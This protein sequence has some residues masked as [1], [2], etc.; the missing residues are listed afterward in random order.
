MHTDASAATR[1][2][3]IEASIAARTLGEQ[4]AV[5]GRG[6]LALD[7]RDGRE[8]VVAVRECGGQD[9]CGDPLG[10]AAG[11]ADRDRAAEGV[12][13]QREAVEALSH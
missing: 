7:R 3:G 1:D 4:L 8:P 11:D 13:G 6:D 2:E 12:A 9:E 10:M 5:A